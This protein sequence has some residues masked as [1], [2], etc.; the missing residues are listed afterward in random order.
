MK[1]L[2]FAGRV[3][4]ISAV[5]VMSPVITTAVTVRD[6][7]ASRPH[8]WVT[9]SINILSPQTEAEI[10]R[11][12]DQLEAKNSCE[13]MVVIVPETKGYS[14]PREFA[15]AW[16]NYWTIGKKGLDN[17]VLL[18]YSRGDDRPGETPRD[19]IEIVTGW[20]IRSMLP[21]AEVVSLIQ[22][23]IRP[24]VNQRDYDGAM[25]IVLQ[26]VAKVLQNYQPNYQP[27]VS[28]SEPQS[29]LDTGF[30]VSFFMF[31]MYGIYG[32]IKNWGRGSHSHNRSTGKL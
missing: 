13:I 1:L 16:F 7:P 21:D 32:A 15:L 29:L 24:R 10:N 8:S 30:S 25:L 4:L 14:S 11:I 5:I 20:G 31:I 23:D 26:D 28:P 22:R 17:G 9:D 27:K 3:A 2:A 19:R 12:A 18:M 6:V